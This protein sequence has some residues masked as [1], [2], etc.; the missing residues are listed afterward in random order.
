M[1]PTDGVRR[2]GASDQQERPCSA[3]DGKFATNAVMVRAVALQRFADGLTNHRRTNPR[4]SCLFVFH[5]CSPAVRRVSLS[6]T[7][8][9]NRTPTRD[10]G[11]NAF[12]KLL[13]RTQELR[14]RRLFSDP[15]PEPAPGGGLRSTPP[16]ANH[17]VLG[18]SPARKGGF[19]PSPADSSYVERSAEP[20]RITSDRV[21]R[22]VRSTLP[23]CVYAARLPRYV[24]PSVTGLSAAQ[25]GTRAPTAR[26]R[27]TDQTGTPAR[28]LR[29]SSR[30]DGNSRSSSPL[31][32]PVR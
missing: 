26:H 18:K 31:A 17:T 15:T 6:R 27:L 32:T 25:D 9:T 2:R 7:P 14:Q 10:C 11:D 20:R 1:P 28:A 29:R 4:F 16:G 22:R 13:Q 12:I 3:L 8:E 5:G 30:A 24:R 19:A 23:R 21:R